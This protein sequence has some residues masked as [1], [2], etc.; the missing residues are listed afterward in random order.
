MNIS[1]ENLRHIKAWYEDGF[2]EHWCSDYEGIRLFSAAI[3]CRV[4]EELDSRDFDSQ[5]ARA[6]AILRSMPSMQRLAVET[7]TGIWHGLLGGRH[8][9]HL[10]EWIGGTEAEAS[11]LF[12]EGV[13]HARHVAATLYPERMD[14]S[15][16]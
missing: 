12:V 8:I 10:A 13:E 14:A 11:A 15:P 16:E 4:H 3:G 5:D 6:L 2:D 1:S 7:I 9:D